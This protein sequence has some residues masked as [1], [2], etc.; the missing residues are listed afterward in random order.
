MDAATVMLACGSAFAV[1]I[2]LARAG[3][4]AV[5]QLVAGLA[6]GF[7]VGTVRRLL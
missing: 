4:P 3:E 5:V 7:I 2:A 6:I 1:G